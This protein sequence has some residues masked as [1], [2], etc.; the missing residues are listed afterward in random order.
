MSRPFIRLG[1]S[2]SHGGTVT[3]ASPHTDSFGIQVARIGDMTSCPI[4]GHGSPP[5]V[6]GDPT[7]IV[8]GSPV[9]RLGDSTGCGATLIPSQQPTTDLV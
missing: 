9:A 7:L 4:P 6:T 2:T 1:D 5:I 8:D 3:T